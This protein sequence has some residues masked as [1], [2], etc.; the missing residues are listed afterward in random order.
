MNI[1]LIR[2]RY[3]LIFSSLALFF[4][5]LVVMNFSLVS[6]TEESLV[7]FGSNFNPAISAVINA[8]R[9]LY[10]AKVAELEMLASEPNSQQAREHYKSYQENAEQAFDR[11]KKYKQLMSLYPDVL[12]KLTKFESSFKQWEKE[13]NEVFL[14]I[15]NN[16]LAEAIIQSKGVASKRF[17]ELRYFYNLAGE[18]ADNKSL[19][20]SE[21][22]ISAVENRQNVLLIISIIVV[23]LTLITGYAAPKAMADALD[24]LSA[25]LKALNSGDGDLTRRIKT[26][27]KD[28]IGFV[29]ND[30]DEF[31]DGLAVLIKSIVEQSS[32]VIEGVDQLEGGAKNISQTSEHQLESVEMIVTAVNEMSY[33]IAEVAKNAQLTSSDTLEVNRLANEGSAITSDAVKEIKGLSIAVDE[34]TTVISKLSENSKDIASVLDVIR[35]IAEQT[36]LLALNAAIE[37]ARA[38]EQGRG[39]AVV[40]DEVRNLASKTQQSTE[41]IQLM[42]EALHKG[43]EE[44]V[45]AI[46]KGNAATQVS[47]ELSEKTLEALDKIHEASN[48]VADVAAQTATATEEQSQVADD[49][50]KNL[51][52]MSDQTKENHDVSHENSQLAEATME[53]ATK[54]NDS[55]TRFKLS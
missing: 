22:T 15:N 5:I 25:K 40:A 29:A 23:L 1:N 30:F 18:E 50:S 55:V 52:M 47:V 14:L 17:D 20:V 19:F 11:M 46:N 41:N 49:L 53:L 6:M 35:G 8:D 48:R 36:N 34:A 27:R 32:K 33:A 13:S 2:V 31:I 4:I 21:S 42:I 45:T 51:T 26:N 44:A 3:T 38:G 9:D 10:Q 37:A 43:V 24:D 16:Q 39:F 28:E 7:R 12:A 54:L